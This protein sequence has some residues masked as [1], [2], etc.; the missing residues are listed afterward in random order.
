MFGSSIVICGEARVSL[1]NIAQ[2]LV[3][4]MKFGTTAI[5]PDKISSSVIY[6]GKGMQV[7]KVMVFH[8]AGVER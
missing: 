6:D 5:S 3:H 8:F 4:G 1:E 7:S 2:W